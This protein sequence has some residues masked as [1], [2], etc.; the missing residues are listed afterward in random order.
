MTSSKL[1]IS[2]HARDELLSHAREGAAR[3][4]PEEICGV[5]VG[6][7]QARRISSVRPVS[8]IATDPR[9]TYELDPSETVAIFEAVESAG[10]DVIGFYHSHPESAPVPSDTDR[11]RAT[12][13]GY[14]YL[15]C[16]PDGRLTA[17]EWT[18]DD[19]RERGI[20]VE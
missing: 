8:N 7:G 12:W 1:S 9:V 17:H 13:P 2:A 11:E 18:G 4:P 14:V 15:I 16:T 20:I 19:F 3:D 10:D 6:D 5:L